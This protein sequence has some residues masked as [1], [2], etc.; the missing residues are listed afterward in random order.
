MTVR[1]ISDA[2]AQAWAADLASARSELIRGPRPFDPQISRAGLRPR[3]QE[4]L[5]VLDPR[6]YLYKESRF[7]AAL[8]RF[9]ECKNGCAAILPSDTEPDVQKNPSVATCPE[10]VKEQLNF[11]TPAPA[12]TLVFSHS[13]HPIHARC[14]QRA[15]FKGY[16]IN[17][18]Q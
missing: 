14:K 16:F 3:V 4:D 12:S 11:K 15:G 1:S 9:K 8:L 5:K 13:L 7:T 2:V 6:R 10:E 18:L 17:S